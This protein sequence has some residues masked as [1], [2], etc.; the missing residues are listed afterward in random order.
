[1]RNF[2]DIYLDSW[3]NIFNWQDKSPR[4]NFWIFF[5]L[6]FFLNALIFRRL[7]YF[8]ESFL[9]VIWLL[10][11][12][13]A[14]LSLMARRLNDIEYSKW[15]LLLMIVPGGFILLLVFMCIKGIDKQNID[16]NPEI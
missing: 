16:I 8:F 4:E 2:F 12:F 14:N 1:M 9:V 15:W 5:L 3:K 11:M 7:P 13:V 6:N 10:W